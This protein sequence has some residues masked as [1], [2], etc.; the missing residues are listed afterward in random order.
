MTTDFNDFMTFFIITDDDDSEVI[1]TICVL[2]GYQH[3]DD[4][5]IRTISKN[6]KYSH[7]TEINDN[8]HIDKDSGII[9]FCVGSIFTLTRIL[10]FENQK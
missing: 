2:S 8:Q 5:L 3:I 7:I 1:G 9:K 6:E 10:T 4:K